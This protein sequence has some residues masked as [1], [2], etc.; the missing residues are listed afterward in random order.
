ML[1]INLQSTTVLGRKRNSLVNLQ[2]LIPALIINLYSRFL[3]LNDK[4]TFNLYASR[5]L[6]SA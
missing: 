6:Q 2:S 3:Q 5:L 1:A 4:I